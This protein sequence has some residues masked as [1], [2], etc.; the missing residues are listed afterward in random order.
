MLGH[1][2][3]QPNMI[4]IVSSEPY[5]NHWGCEGKDGTIQCLQPERFSFKHTGIP[6]LA[7][8]DEELLATVCMVNMCRAPGTR[9]C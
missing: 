4:G 8:L 3:Q 5:S 2:W 6:A 9:A 7:Q 1:A